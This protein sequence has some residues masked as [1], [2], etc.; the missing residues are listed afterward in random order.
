MG[1]TGK[2]KKR[3]GKVMGQLRK[4]N[5]QVISSKRNARITKK[6]SFFHYVFSADDTLA[7]SS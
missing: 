5:I 2:H 1:T 3:L 4:R 7:D 6:L